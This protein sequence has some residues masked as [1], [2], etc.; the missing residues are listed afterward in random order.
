MV[1]YYE[2]YFELNGEERHHPVE[3]ANKREAR[4]K[5][6]DSGK[7]FDKILSVEFSHSV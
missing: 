3:A 2:V 1:D 7:S 6:K 5:F 4:Q